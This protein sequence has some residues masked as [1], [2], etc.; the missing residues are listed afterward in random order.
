ME[1]ETDKAVVEM[2]APVTG[3]SWRSAGN[4]ARSSPSASCWSSIDDDGDGGTRTGRRSDGE[5]PASHRRQYAT[6][7][8]TTAPAQ[9]SGRPHPTAPRHAGDAWRSPAVSASISAVIGGTGP[10]GRITDDDVTRADIAGSRRADAR[11][12]TRRRRSHRA[13]R[14]DARPSMTR[15]PL[16][17]VRKRT[18]ETMTAAWQ[19]VPHVDSFHEID[20]TD[21]FAVREQLKPIAADRGVAVT[22]TAFLLRATALALVEHPMLN[23]SL[24]ADAGEIVLHGRRDIGVAVDTP[25]GLVLPVVRN[26]D[27]RSL[28][29]L[30]GELGPAR[31]GALAPAG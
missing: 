22:I 19:A 31:R 10:G 20:V 6:P 3:T 11:G 9:P 28:F 17:G 12:G 23:A 30:A 18:A 13:R 16:R 8:A 29:D 21:L 5:R 4:P 24:D 26:A 1:I 2:P 15:I 25:D 7:A 14:R 27:E